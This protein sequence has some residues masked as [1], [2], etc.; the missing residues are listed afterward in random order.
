LSAGFFG[1]KDLVVVFGLAC[2]YRYKINFKIN[3]NP[4]DN[5]K[6]LRAKKRRSG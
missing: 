5:R 4:K 3:G 6:V 1:A 2:S